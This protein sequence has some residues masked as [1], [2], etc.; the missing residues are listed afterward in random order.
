MRSSSRF[1]GTQASNAISASA[2]TAVTGNFPIF[3][4][5]LEASKTG[6]HV[7]SC[8][9][10]N[11]FAPQPGGL[12]GYGI[13]CFGV[14]IPRE[15]TACYENRRIADT[16]L[17]NLHS[18]PS[19]PSCWTPRS[20]PRSLGVQLEVRWIARDADP[21]EGRSALPGSDSFLS[22]QH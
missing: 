3:K 12:P 20:Q 14:G 2:D 4:F 10:I 1:L 15:V 18:N 11:C 5:L 19:P 7:T 17:S 8:N 9:E 21:P 13:M 22:R 16:V 6:W